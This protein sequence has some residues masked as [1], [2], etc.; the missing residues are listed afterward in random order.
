MSGSELIPINPNARLIVD[1]QKSLEYYLEKAKPVGKFVRNQVVVTGAY[2]NEDFLPGYTA[3]TRIFAGIWTQDTRSGLYV[4]F[5]PI[6]S[7]HVPI[8]LFNQA[9]K[10][11]FV[12]NYDVRSGR[13]TK[14]FNSYEPNLSINF[15]EL[16]RLHAAASL[17]T[18]VMDGYRVR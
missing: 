13:N 14:T 8:A 5:G 10:W 17:F 9:P 16:S 12:Y 4:R 1:F 11:A 3:Y 15:E 18:S 6:D 2:D 7:P